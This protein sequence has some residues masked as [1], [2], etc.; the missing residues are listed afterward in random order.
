MA[1]NVLKSDRAIEMSLFVIRAFVKMRLLLTERGEFARRL[2]RIERKLLRHDTALQEIHR[3]IR[4]LR[5]E[6]EASTRRRI[7]FQS[8]E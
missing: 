3:E 2:D 1:A 7:G 4:A 6:T 8:D 5:Q